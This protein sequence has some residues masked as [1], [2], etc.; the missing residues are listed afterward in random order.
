MKYLDFAGQT[1]DGKYHIE[2]ELGRGGMGTVY[3]ATHLGTERPV[4]VKI[5]A[6]QF[7]QRAEFVERFRREARAAGRLRHPNVVDVTDF[8]FAD[9]RGGQVA[10]LVMEYLDGC[11]LG[12]ILDEERNLPVGWTLDILEQ[13]CSAVQE[14]HEQGIIHRD[15]KPDNIWL[16]PNQRGGYT[17]KV[18]DFGI[19]KL[20]E[21][22]ISNGDIP[23][24]F[25]RSTHTLAGD[26]KTTIGG[27]ISTIGAEASTIV[28][29]ADL[30]TM[31]NEGGTISLEPL[32]D[33]NQTAIYDDRSD[34]QDSVGTRMISDEIDV[35]T[36]RT[37][38]QRTTGKSLIDSPTTAGLT[39]VG[40]VLGTPLY[41]SPEQCRGEHLDPRSDIY[42]LGV[43][44]Y[45][46]LSGRTPFE[47]DFKDVME[48]HKTVAP[49]PLAA[50]KVR[51]KM[52][53]AILS[54]LD[55]DP[56]NR[57]QTAEA[58]ASVMRSRSEG[59]FGLLRR[60]L[61][62]YS[63]HLPKFLMLTTFFSLPSIILTLT[64]VALSFLKVSEI[65]SGTS[66][67]VAIGVVVLLL[68]LA[69]AFSTYL[70][71]GTI[72][73]IV[74]QYL[75]VPLRPVRLRP[76]LVEARKRWKAFAGTGILST[77]L[78]FAI[79]I[80]TCGIG[81]LVTNVLWTLVSPVVMMENRSGKAALRR[82][83]DLV[84][85]SVGTAIGAV[86]ML[87]LIPAIFS[88]TVS[89]VVNITAR[90]IDPKPQTP[91]AV[92]EQA[93]TD[94]SPVVSTT[95]P[96]TSAV[97][98]E[99]AKTEDGGLNINIGPNRTIR[100]DDDEMDMRSRV[101]KTILESLVQVI[102]LP[103]QIFVL[104]F[105]AIIIALLYLKTRL[106]GGES[107]NE[108]IER[109]E[110]DDGPRKKWQE[111]VRQRLIQSGRIPSKS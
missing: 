27:N 99:P 3:L 83:K 64:L 110:S 32:A 16:E 91:A 92:T 60:A 65:I 17:V 84:K 33:E 86:F 79:G 47:G 14:A 89:F 62:I 15:L 81:F 38:R 23:I 36:D 4:A 8:G 109:F 70:N 107:M 63:E 105:S 82:S 59:L 102:W 9:T 58:F 100:V 76:A 39:R 103:L 77:F 29:T 48:S 71:I 53:K 108:L 68:G 85:R 90:A 66:A 72:T 101:K 42:S 21:H 46:M 67:N 20:E 88:G 80:P 45:Q 10:Y 50:K 11:T 106:A 49:P 7:M 75:A 35:E 19:A 111:R 74:T 22:E 25:V 52:Q 44:A 93:R 5:I 12:E 43:I 56:G 51:R 28:Q 57:P 69:S 13:V 1:L 40:A 24:E 37:G 61:V 54:A 2:R 41:M 18:L 31:V 6:P 87:F 98:P 94:G 55:K 78:M 34:D 26:A 73:W 96:N 104:S 95:D 30:G 97:P